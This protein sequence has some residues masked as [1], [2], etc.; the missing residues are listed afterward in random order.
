[1]TTERITDKPHSDESGPSREIITASCLAGE[2]S[3]FITMHLTPAEEREYNRGMAEL[4]E[5]G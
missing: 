2:H 5:W 1:M 3:G 4:A